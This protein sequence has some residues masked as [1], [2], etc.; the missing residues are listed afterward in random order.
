MA[1]LEHLEEYEMR[2][3][4]FW[5]QAEQFRARVVETAAIGAV[6]NSSQLEHLNM[7]FKS[8]QLVAWSVDAAIKK[9]RS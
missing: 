6:W 1:K 4:E 3:K 9:N 2:M 8:I 7:L 5:D